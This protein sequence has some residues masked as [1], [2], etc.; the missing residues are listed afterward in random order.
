MMLWM[1]SLPILLLERRSA[2]REQAPDDSV[3]FTRSA[4]SAVS[5]LS[6]RS[7]YLPGWREN[8]TQRMGRMWGGVVLEG[9]V[10]AADAVE[11]HLK[12]NR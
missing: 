6:V 9:D 11:K 1:P 12:P 2:E 7:R 3:T 8:L 10:E 4:V 5:S